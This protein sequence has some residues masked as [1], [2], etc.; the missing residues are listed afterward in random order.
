MLKCH[1]TVNNE[2]FEPFQ[3]D[4]VKNIKVV[5]GQEVHRMYL[6]FPLDTIVMKFIERFPIKFVSKSTIKRIV[7]KKLVHLVLPVQR[8]DPKNKCIILYTINMTLKSK[9]A[10]L[11]LMFFLHILEKI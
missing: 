8:Q 11:D 4:K 1:F 7:R 10:Y 6:R 5:D 3:G 2:S 9:H